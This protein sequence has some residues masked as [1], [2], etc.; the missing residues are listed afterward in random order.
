[1]L[2]AADWGLVV[3]DVTTYTAAHDGYATA[4]AACT[5][6]VRNKPAVVAKNSARD[7]LKSAAAVVANKI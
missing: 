2:T 6:S 7:I 1:M 4:L 3:G 5:P